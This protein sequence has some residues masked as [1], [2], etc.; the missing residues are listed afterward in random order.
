MLD[1]DPF[2]PES[3]ERNRRGKL[4]TA[5]ELQMIEA[6]INWADRI[7]LQ[8]ATVKDGVST[9]TL[10]DNTSLTREKI[11]ALVNRSRKYDELKLAVK[12]ALDSEVI[13]QA[14]FAGYSEA[15]SDLRDLV[16]KPKQRKYEI[17]RKEN[18]GAS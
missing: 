8:T 18:H 17:I 10:Y 12:R 7:E 3:F 15:I 5:D 14:P 1:R 11:Q 13:R 4:M 9:F 6:S 2:G 16:T